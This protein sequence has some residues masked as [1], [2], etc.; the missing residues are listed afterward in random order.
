MFR[1]LWKTAKFFLLIVIVL[2]CLPHSILPR[3][4]KAIKKDDL[5]SYIKLNN[6]ELRLAEYKDD[7]EGL[8]L[9]LSQLEIIN[10]SRKNYKADPVSLDILASRVANKMCREA[11]EKNFLGHWNLAGE[12]PYHRYAFAGG[13]DHVTENAFGQ[14]SSENYIKSGPLISSMMKSGHATFMAEKIP[15]DGHKKN[16]IDK[17][18]NSVGIGYYLAGKQ[19]RYYEEFLDRYLDFEDIPAETGIDEKCSITVNTDGKSFLYYLVIYREDF[20]KPVRAEEISKKGSYE[21]YSDEQYLKMAAWDLA[22]YRNGSEYKIPLSFSKGGLYYIQIFTDKKEIT[23]AASVS[24]KGK[25]PVSGIVIKV[26]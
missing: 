14:W 23:G 15:Y 24:T 17:S 13:Y 19:F 8:K 10:N 22:A 5:E 20:P 3:Q 9:K 16:I 6:K 7:E 4:I 11:T 1:K 26:R 2:I 25:T 21:D 18:H 12:K